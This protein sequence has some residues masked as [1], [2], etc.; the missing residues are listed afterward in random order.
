MDAKFTIPYG[1][2][3]VIEALKKE[4]KGFSVFLPSSRQEKGIDLLLMKSDETKNT[5]ITIQVKQSRTYYDQ[6]IITV[7]GE[8]IPVVGHLWFNRFAVPQNADWFILVGIHYVQTKP[9]KNASV[10]SFVLDQI[11]L[12]FTKDEITDFLNNLKQKKKDLL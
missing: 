12:A 5:H 1:E 8:T 3:A 9:R 2:F 10:R 7:D 6:K 11:L 4:M